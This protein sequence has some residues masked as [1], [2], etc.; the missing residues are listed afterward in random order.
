MLLIGQILSSINQPMSL[1]NTKSPCGHTIT[2]P[3]HK[4][5]LINNVTPKIPFIKHHIP[6]TKD[7]LN[8]NGKR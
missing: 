6:Q 5:V 4:D 8:A 3:D 2:C 7:E 1:S